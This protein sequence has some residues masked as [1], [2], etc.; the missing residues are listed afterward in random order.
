[1]LTQRFDEAFRYAHGLH[2]NQTRKG[3]AILRIPTIATSHSS[4]SRPV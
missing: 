1:M 2:Q 4:A 3:T